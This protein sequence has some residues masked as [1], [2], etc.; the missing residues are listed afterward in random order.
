MNSVED[1]TKN[2]FDILREE[3]TVE[4]YSPVRDRVLVKPVADPAGENEHGI[5][6]PEEDKKWRAIVMAV[7]PGRKT[8]KGRIPPPVE[9]GDLIIMGAYI[10]ERLELNRQEYRLVKASDM[11]AVIKDV[12]NNTE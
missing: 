6:T 10:G 9:P 2:L 3:T 12:D 4:N 8:K 11:L 1:A 7:G 5:W